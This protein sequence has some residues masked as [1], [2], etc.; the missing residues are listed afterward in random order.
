[1]LAGV[2]ASVRGGAEIEGALQELRLLVERL[3][4]LLQ[5]KKIAVSIY[6][7]TNSTRLRN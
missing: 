7:E 6:T 5:L 1:M 2:G 4:E 3:C